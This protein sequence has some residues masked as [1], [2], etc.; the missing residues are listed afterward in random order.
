MSNQL[1]MVEYLSARK[2]AMRVWR[3]GRQM[4]YIV[5]IIL[6]REL[7]TSCLLFIFQCGKTVKNNFGRNTLFFF[8]HIPGNLMI[9]NS[10]STV[11]IP[12]DSHQTDTIWG[13]P[14]T[15]RPIILCSYAYYYYYVKLASLKR[16]FLRIHFNIIQYYLILKQITGN[17][18][19]I[20]LLL[21]YCNVSLPIYLLI[22]KLSHD[23]DQTMIMCL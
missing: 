8:S 20:L 15:W 10:P 22:A 3:H 13:S 11:I 4:E 9:Q 23:A 12:T 18:F 17:K 1:K 16:Q 14:H 2:T 5:S 6:C 21:C 7:P 19:Y